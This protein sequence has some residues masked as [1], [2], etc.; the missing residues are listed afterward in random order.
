MF[1]FYA[2]NENSSRSQENRPPEGAQRPRGF[3]RSN[4]DTACECLPRKERSKT[5]STSATIRDPSNLGQSE[6]GDDA[7]VRSPESL[8]AVEERTKVPLPAYSL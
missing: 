4:S 8:G 1:D 6:A 7:D 3:R 5:P 2:A